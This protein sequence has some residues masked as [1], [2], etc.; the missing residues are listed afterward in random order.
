[1]SERKYWFKAKKNGL[2]W[3]TPLTWQ[4]WMVYVSLFAAMAYFFFDGRDVG[5]KIL[6]VWIPILL[7]LPVCWIFGEPLSAGRSAR[8]D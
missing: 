2:G 4:G 6:G 8:K 7:A 5:E 1:M 3:S